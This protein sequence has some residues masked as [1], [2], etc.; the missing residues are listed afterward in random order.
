[1]AQDGDYDGELPEI[2]SKLASHFIEAKIKHFSFNELDKAL[3][4]VKNDYTIEWDGGFQIEIFL[5]DGRITKNTS[6]AIKP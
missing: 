6:T 2:M 4:W 1:M 3:Q 5:V